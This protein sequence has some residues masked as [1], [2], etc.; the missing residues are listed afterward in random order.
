MKITSDDKQSEVLIES[1]HSA[2]ATYHNCFVPE[3]REEREAYFECMLR[4]FS[5]VP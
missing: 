3:T 5:D 4:S 1:C 2:L